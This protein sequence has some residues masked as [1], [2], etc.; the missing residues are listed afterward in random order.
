MGI[1]AFSGPK[2]SFGLTRSASGQIQEYNE[3][4]GPDV[5]DAGYG[6]ADPRAP[7]TYKPGNAVGYGVF[8]W[9]N[10]VGMIDQSPGTV[11]TNAVALVQSSTTPAATF[12]LSSVSNSVATIGVTLTPADGSSARTVVALD[13]TY[14]TGPRGLTYGQFG[15]IRMWDPTTSLQRQITIGKGSS[16]DDTGATYTIQGFDNYGFK[17]TEVLTGSSSTG[18]SNY[19]SRKTYKYI[20]SITLGGTGTAGSSTVVIGVNDTY[21][22]PLAVHD[23]SG[24]LIWSGVSSMMNV[25]TA[26]SSFMVFASTNTAT[27]TTAD[28]RGTW[29]STIVSNSTQAAPQRVK[30][31]VTPRAQD[32]Q[33]MTGTYLSS[34][35]HMWIGVDQFSS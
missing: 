27:S 11:S 9:F 34:G 33:I 22:F 6:I 13:S 2:I 26:Q 14:A 5:S 35:P 17:I 7:Y 4:R 19:T 10:G 8:G 20:Q 1:T 3:E 29:A 12:V 23:G 30:I 16:L 15:T 18:S 25:M 28:T 32:M 24:V 31:I 21:G